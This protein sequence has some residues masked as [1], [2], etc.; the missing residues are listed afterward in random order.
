MVDGL[1][2]DGFWYG[3]YVPGP[4]CFLEIELA[5]SKQLSLA[6]LL[7]KTAVGKA[8]TNFLEL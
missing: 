3:S 6:T 1:V 5:Q 8:A 2:F 4:R 7:L